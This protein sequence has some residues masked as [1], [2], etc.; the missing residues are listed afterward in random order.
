MGGQGPIKGSVEPSPPAPSNSGFLS[1]SPKEEVTPSGTMKL[2]LSPKPAT[3]VV[4]MRGSK[5]P[6]SSRTLRAPPLQPLPCGAVA[7]NV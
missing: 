1:N 6:P 7:T 2:A 5:G 4:R 3:S